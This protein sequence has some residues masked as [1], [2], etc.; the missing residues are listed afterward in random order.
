M[1]A[2][3]SAFIGN[4]QLKYS[5][6]REYFTVGIPAVIALLFMLGC[7]ALGVID[8]GM[9]QE[10]PGSEKS[11]KQK[12]YEAMLAGMAGEDGTAASVPAEAQEKK[13][14]K[15]A[16]GLDSAIIFAAL[17]TMTPFAID[18]TVQK[19]RMRKKEEL[20]TEFLFKMSELMRGGLDPIKA[21]RELAK[22]DLGLL[23][24]DIRF[25]ANSMNYGKSFEEAMRFMS[26][27]LKSELI[28]RYTE[29]VIQASYSGG[30]VSDLILKSSEDMRGILGIER[31]KEGNLKQYVMIFYFAQGIL[32]FIAYTM[33]SSL[34]PYLQSMGATSFFGKNEIAGLNFPLGF[35][36]LLMINS[37]F[38]GL[39]IGKISEGDAKYGLKH[40]VILMVG[41]YIAC[42]AVLLAPPAGN[43]YGEA[44]ITVVGGLGQA[45]TVGLP[46]PEPIVFLVTDKEGKP[47][48]RASISYSV[49]PE[50]RLSPSTGTTGTD[51]KDQVR[52]ILGE[53]AGTYIIEAKVG[54]LTARTTAAAG[55]E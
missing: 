10:Q 53:K 13:P 12:A 41:C 23:N 3:L 40:V 14:A 4:L 19:A 21:V 22:T 18:V 55:K 42:M 39:I 36:H 5:L 43:S 9:G 33:T 31:E 26:R 15:M 28:S 44:N 30:S 29:L 38:G 35:F 25:A 47:I 32:F 11:D 49:T 8:T 45:G 16:M 24:Q 37:F 20:F 51:G 2:N 50:G 7:F 17:I 27:S 52:V 6:P 34:L 46:L 1:N 54:K 48:P